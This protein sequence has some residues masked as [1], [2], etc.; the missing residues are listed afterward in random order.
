ML[1]LITTFLI[2]ISLYIKWPIEMIDIFKNGFDFF[3]DIYLQI[4]E[5]FIN[6]ILFL[7]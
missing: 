2:M 3:N 4:I 7:I 5:E 6:L 1:S